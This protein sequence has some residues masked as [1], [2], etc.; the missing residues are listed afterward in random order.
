MQFLCSKPIEIVLP[1]RASYH[2]LPF[3]GLFFVARLILFPL[4]YCDS[5]E[6]N[7]YRNLPDFKDPQHANILEI[8]KMRFYCYKNNSFRII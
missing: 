1:H 7:V 5:T 3:L 8:L 4:C 6:R 2:S